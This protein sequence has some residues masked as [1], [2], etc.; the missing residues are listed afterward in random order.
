[1]RPVCDSLSLSLRRWVRPLQTLVRQAALAFACQQHDQ[2]V[3]CSEGGALSVPI[4]H[5]SP[6]SL[7]YNKTTK[8]AGL[9]MVGG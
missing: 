9:T 2:R 4:A 1:M 3:T 7:G 5:P 8:G 6:L